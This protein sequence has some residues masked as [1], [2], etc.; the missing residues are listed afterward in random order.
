[1]SQAV[2]TASKTI[3]S[4]DSIAAAWF[5]RGRAHHRLRRYSEAIFD[6]DTAERLRGSPSPDI[7]HLRIDAL[8][9]QG[10]LVSLR[11]MQMDLTSLLQLDPSDQTRTLVAELLLDFAA[12]AQGPERRATLGRVK[13][14]L[15]PI[16]SDYARAAVARA[17]LLEIDN[18][19]PQ[20]LA[21]M[22]AALTQHAGN[23]LVHVEAAK[24][25]ARNGLPAESQREHALA[26]R[27]QP[28]RA[29]N[30]TAAAVPVDLDGLSNF[31]GAVDQVL[32]A[33]DDGS[34]P[35]RQPPPKK[36]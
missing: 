17:R 13:E 36:D 4:D 19:I 20:A 35:A 23:I 18:A 8:R 26:Q 27:I 3:A 6:F 33:L 11:R 10:D 7:L 32:K 2:A 5:V 16:G 25:F 21:S 28:D 29:G 30:P 15:S 1:M 9:Q 14:I 24:M 12:Q 34:K 31:L 22:R